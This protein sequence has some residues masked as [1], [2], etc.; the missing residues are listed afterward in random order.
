MSEFFQLFAM[1]KPPTTI[2]DHLNT[3]P[4]MSEKSRHWL[5]MVTHW[6]AWM[7]E[8]EKRM[9]DDDERLLAE[10]VSM[11]DGVKIT[12]VKQATLLEVKD[13]VQI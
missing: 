2:I 9:T 12:E 1:L 5:S 8:L 13:K 11:F 6:D 4:K 7:V 3:Y 10:L